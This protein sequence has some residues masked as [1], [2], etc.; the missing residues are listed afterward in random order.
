[1]ASLRPPRARVLI[2]ED[3]EKSADALL[4]ALQPSCVCEIAT[5]PA[6]ALDALARD[7]FDVVVSDTSV[8]GASGLDLL[9]AV[10]GRSPEVPFIMMAAA[11]DEAG[12]IEASRRGAFAAMM[13]PVDG[14]ELSSSVQRAV[15]DR[16]HRTRDPA[17]PTVV[18]S[19][20][21]F[22]KTLAAIDQVAHSTAPVLLVGETGSGKDVLAARIHAR[23]PRRHRPFLVVNAGAISPSVLDSE[24]FGHAAGAFTGATRPRR[25]LIA[26]ADGGTLFLDEIA[27][28]PLELQG[29]LLRVLETGNTRA[30][31]SDH[32]HHVDVRFVAATQH[33]LLQAVH[34][35]HFREDLYFRLNVLTIDVPPLRERRDDIVPLARYFLDRARVRN[36]RSPATTLSAA[37]E[38]HLVSQQWPGNVRELAS[39]IERAVVFASETVV[40]TTRMSATPTD[41]KTFSMPGLPEKPCSLKTLT[42]RYIAWVLTRANGDKARAAAILGVDVSTLYR[43]QRKRDD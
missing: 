34:A 5:S 20:A 25:G 38:K 6:A 21:S 2:L 18:G 39:V 24:L 43:W 32:E 41:A 3:D 17:E 1:M 8:A 10:H 28:L 36:P 33:D 23:G 26:E 22:M 12:V 7:R 31:G 29:R 15:A 35:G 13:K 14:G 27:D 42:S 16:E 37:S 9:D 19:S 40:D 11:S 30:V 4:A